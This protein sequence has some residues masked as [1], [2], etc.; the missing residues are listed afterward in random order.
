MVFE[1]IIGFFCER[2]ILRVNFRNEESD[3]DGE[4]V[5]GGRAAGQLY[6]V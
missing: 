1:I 2:A 6:V 5:N 4:L 3:T